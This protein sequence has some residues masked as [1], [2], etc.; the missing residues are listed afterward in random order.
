L[1]AGAKERSSIMSNPPRAEAEHPAPLLAGCISRDDLAQE[2]G[3]A[4][5][6]LGRWA[7]RR[8]GPPCIRIG[9]RVFYRRTA[10]QDW[11][12][13]QEQPKPNLKTRR[14]K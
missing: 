8:E 10:V 12:R 6:T 14:R 4:P 11:I 1:F 5:D 9:R 3:L 13:T 2:L 7:S